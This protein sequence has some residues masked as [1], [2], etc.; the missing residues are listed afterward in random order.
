M[1]F[2]TLFT[3]NTP[4]DCH[5]LGARLLSEGIPYYVFDENIVWVDPFKAIAVGGVKL[6]TEAHRLDDA[7]HLMKSIER[8]KLTDDSGEYELAGIFE[9]EFKRQESILAVKYQLRNDP[10]LLEDPSGMDHHS[11]SNSDIEEVLNEEREFAR[12]RGLKSEFSWKQF[13]YELFDYNRDVFKYLNPRTVSYYIEKELVDKYM[14]P[15]KAG[16]GLTCPNCNSDNVAYGHAT[17]HAWD[18]IY[19]VVSILLL[20]PLYPLRKKNHCFD[21]GY[22]FN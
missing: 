10:G 9:N 12:M 19:I 7:I 18:F 8:G 17:D 1:G 2:K 11:L 13:L 20:A 14:T 21:C 3:S 5:I 16:S 22:N 6:K 15:G 4:I